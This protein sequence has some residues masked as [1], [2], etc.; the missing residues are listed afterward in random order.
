MRNEEIQE[1]SALGERLKRENFVEVP[2]TSSRVYLDVL[3][4][5]EAV[6]RHLQQ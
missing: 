6:T 4:S 2:L 1:P 5:N 3:A